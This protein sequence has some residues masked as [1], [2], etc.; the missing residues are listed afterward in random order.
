MRRREF[1]KLSAAGGAALVVGF[2]ID[3]ESSSSFQPNGWVRI[4]ASGKIVLTVG[5]QEMGQGVRTS[6]P[7]ILADELDADW[8]SIALTQA[9]PSQQFQR[10]GTGGSGSVY[11][12]WKP[13]RTAGA[14]ARTMLVGAA[15]AKWSVDA[16]ACRTEKGF[17]INTKTNE[18][19][20]YGALASDAAKQPVPA[21]PKLKAMSELRIVGQ[22]VKKFDAPDIVT[23]KAIYGLDAR[24]PGMLYASIERPPSVGGKLVTF[25]PAKAM[26]VSG[27][28]SVVAI[29]A[30]VA[31][32][33]DNTWAA[34]KG[35]EALDITWDAGPNRAFNSDDHIKALEAAASE[36]GVTIRKEGEGA[37]ALAGAAKTIEARYHYPFY[38]HA[39][40]EPMNCVA[41][42][43]DG[44]CELRMPTQA[45][46][47]AQALVAEA[48]GIK[49]ENVIVHPTLIGGG[50]GRRLWIDYALEA[51]E[52]SRAIA[53]PVQVVWTRQD[54]M[55]HGHFQAESV[56]QLRAGF[57]ENN[58]PMFWG[59]KKVSSYHNLRGAPSAQ[60]R[61][62]VEY[63]QDSAWGVYDVPYAFPS[64]EAT[65]LSIDVPVP[66]G[67]W[68]AVFSPSSTFARECFVDEVAQHLGK[69][70]LQF[71]LDMLGE[72]YNITA[73]SLKIDR[74]RLRR[75]L[76]IVRDKS[77]W[78]S[79][80]ANGR[81]RGVACNVYDGDTHI[82]YVV[83][84]TAR[85]NKV[86]V[87][88]VVAAVDCGVVINPTGI[89][90]QIEGGIIWGLSSALKGHITF[91]DGHAEQSTY[92]DFEVL[93]M[94]ETPAIEIHIVP[95]HGE[96]PFGMGEPPVPPIV[97]AVVN[98]IFAATGKRVRSLPI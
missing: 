3:A 81:G 65:Y 91:R 32:V 61:A 70:P 64:I 45:P 77:K 50:F 17:V 4:E 97:P 74:T 20:S 12:S 25:D 95:S 22:R 93:R 21:E 89:E 85:E 18:R 78:G 9:E 83:E 79:R 57:D 2:R 94:N 30:G 72:P 49:P 96:Q 98:A 36:P 24:M 27:V 6:L 52:L 69:D 47:R 59:H 13:L 76:E 68:R 51:A 5:K 58:A 82:A 11:G 60:E 8:Q 90:Q 92:R 19:L 44:T 43:R 31:V 66:I 55:R 14:A 33:A 62:D 15:A 1:L 7:M 46:N 67:P 87:D 29:K 63:N 41:S 56:H 40:V 73:G 42:F 16:A 39:P 34:M 38:A 28:R 88:R 71:R 23:G 10:L 75:V 35:R 37:A 86:R 54:D 84:V 80:L 48:L 53:N 26:K